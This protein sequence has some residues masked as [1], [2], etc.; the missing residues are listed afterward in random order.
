MTTMAMRVFTW[1]KGELIGEDEF[2]NRY[3][4]ERGRLSRNRRRR[5]VI[6]KG[7]I[8]ASKTPPGWHAWL[9]RTSEAPPSEQPLENKP[10]QKPHMPNLSGTAQ[11][12]QTPGQKSRD[13]SM[14]PPYEAWRPS[15]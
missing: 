13:Q 7:V 2:G 12:Y 6:Y 11:A 1:W 8:E 4:H 10:W 9:H 3:Y 5:W 14:P 15:E